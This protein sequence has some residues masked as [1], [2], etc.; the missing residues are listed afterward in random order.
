MAGALRCSNRTRAGTTRFAMAAPSPD[1]A[2]PSALCRTP[3]P[4]TLAAP[5]AGNG[6]LGFLEIGFPASHRHLGQRPREPRSFRGASARYAVGRK[7]AGI[8]GLL[9][10]RPPPRAD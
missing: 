7:R 4:R 1:A 6:L 2:Y 8:F 9:R 3:R 5:V 10:R